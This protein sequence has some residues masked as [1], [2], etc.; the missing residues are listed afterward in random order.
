MTT[1]AE[2]MKD[3]TIRNLKKEKGT[4]KSTI[5]DQAAD[6]F[7]VAAV[8]LVWTVR[9]LFGLGYNALEIQE[10]AKVVSVEVERYT[11]KKKAEPVAK[12]PVK[13]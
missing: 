6:P 9:E 7:R 4:I 11:K 13:K 1:M 8:E 5:F 3:R 12:K 10:L 2:K